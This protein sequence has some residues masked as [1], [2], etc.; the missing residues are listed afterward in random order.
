M[1][2][3]KPSTVGLVLQGHYSILEPILQ[4]VKEKGGFLC[5]TSKPNKL[6]MSHCDGLIRPTPG[7]PSSTTPI[8]ARDRRSAGFRPLL[9]PQAP[10]IPFAQE[11]RRCCCWGERS[12]LQGLVLTIRETYSYW[13]RN[14]TT[15][16][17][18]L[19]SLS[20]STPLLMI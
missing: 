10:P 17:V 4:C 18:L 11:P 19:G 8:T 16:G 5:L 15:L 7:K 1:F 6:V 14:T 3:L 13:S 2:P 20:K 12:A 9:P